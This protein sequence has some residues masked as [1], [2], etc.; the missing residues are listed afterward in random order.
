MRYTD[1]IACCTKHSCSIVLL[2]HT[3]YRSYCYL[4]FSVAKALHLVDLL[5]LPGVQVERPHEA[6]VHTE[7]AV[8]AT[9]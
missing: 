4:S 8:N 2:E 7:I 5:S 1:V 3:V 6:D 9:A